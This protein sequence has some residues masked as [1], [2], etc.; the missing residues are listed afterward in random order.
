ML[1]NSETYRDA[2]ESRR[3]L[4]LRLV[5]EAGNQSG[6]LAAAESLGLT[7]YLNQGVC[8]L[9]IRLDIDP[10]LLPIDIYASQC[11][12]AGM[13]FSSGLLDRNI[14]HIYHC[15]GSGTIVFHLFLERGGKPDR[16]S[17]AAGALSFEL[18]YSYPHEYRIGKLARGPRE[19]GDTCRSV[20]D[21]SGWTM[22]QLQGAARHP[23]RGAPKV[24]E[25]IYIIER[26]KAASELTV[27]S[28]AAAVGLTPAHFSRVFHRDTG[29][30]P[31]NYLT[32]CRLTRAKRL[33]ENP[34]LRVHDVA[35]ESGFESTEYFAR[36]FRR[37]TGMTPTEYRSDT[38]PADRD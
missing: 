21:S 5:T 26:K 33:L 20:M 37:H 23:E 13:S 31:Q 28:L 25:A 4:S 16:L 2:A 35:L 14:R 24:R 6:A 12:E 27:S 22:P 36:V 19:I 30:S 3:M 29:L 9:F 7:P 15:D 32:A 8:S 10:R 17:D 18:A 11:L 34:D 1:S 38:R